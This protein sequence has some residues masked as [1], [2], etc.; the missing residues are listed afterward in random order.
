MSQTKYRYG[1][2]FDKK[3]NEQ[4]TKEWKSMKPRKPTQQ[5]LSLSKKKKQAAESGQL[6]P[7]TKPDV[8]NYV[9]GVKDGL[10]QV[11]WKDDSQ[12]VGLKV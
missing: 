12:V 10:K 11:I 1:Q 7:I 6:R 8:G 4:I 9:K 3:I 2:V 5:E